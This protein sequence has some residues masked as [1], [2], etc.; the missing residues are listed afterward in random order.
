MLISNQVERPHREIPRHRFRLHCSTP[1]KLKLPVI[2]SSHVQ[3][4]LTRPHQEGCSFVVPGRISFIKVNFRR[5]RGKNVFILARPKVMTDP[6]R[7]PMDLPKTSC[8]LH[9]QIDDHHVVAGRPIG[10]CISTWELHWLQPVF[11]SPLL[12]DFSI[13]DS[14]YWPTTTSINA[15]P[16]SWSTTPNFYARN[17][18]VRL[19]LGKVRLYKANTHSGDRNFGCWACSGGERPTEMVIL[20]QSELSD[21][22]ILSIIYCFPT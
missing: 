17:S 11:L 4:S 9:I 5:V 2:P 12:I 21:I 15:G 7:N 14:R 19:W 20:P 13:V 6:E 22:A 1:W 3:R 8:D 16:P 10:K 18:C